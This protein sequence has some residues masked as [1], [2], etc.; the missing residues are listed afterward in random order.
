MLSYAWG[1]SN[2]SIPDHYRY[3][4]IVDNLE[5]TAFPNVLQPVAFT[6]TAVCVYADRHATALNIHASADPFCLLF[7]LLIQWAVC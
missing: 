2:I 3:S 6:V 7:R 4:S 1:G 5:I